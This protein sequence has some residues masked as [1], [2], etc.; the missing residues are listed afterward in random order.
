L[1]SHAFTFVRDHTQGAGIDIS[2]NA[3][4]FI[5]ASTLAQVIS[6]T[7]YTGSFPGTLDNIDGP[8]TLQNC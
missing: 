3:K 2:S 1:W 6:N 7:S 5:D 4:V 8:Y